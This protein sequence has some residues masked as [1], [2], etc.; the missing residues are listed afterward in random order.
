MMFFEW[1]NKI[2][3][4]W[5]FLFLAA[6]HVLLYY[7]LGNPNWIVLALVAAL[8]ETGVIAS[9]QSIGKLTKSK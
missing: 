6:A 5:A 7:S 1:I 9:L 3:L 2:N 4:L 8:V